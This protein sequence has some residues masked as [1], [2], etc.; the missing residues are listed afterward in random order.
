[1][2]YKITALKVQKRNPNRVNLYLDGEYAFGLSRIVAAWLSIGQALN[3]ERIKELQEQ[4]AD[5]V[6]LQSAL[7]YLNYRPRTEAE[8]SKHLV[9]KGFSEAAVDRVMNRLREGRLLDDRQFARDWVENQNTFRPRGK[10]AL[11]FELR[12]KGISDEIIEQALADSEDEAELAYQAAYRQAQRLCGS[13]WQE[14]RLKLSQYLARRG[15]NYEIASAAV[16]RSWAELCS[17]QAQDS[18]EDMNGE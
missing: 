6:A 1:M 16:R 3:D 2:D 8:I 4:D 12:H 14:F 9:E 17:S 10:R 18:V 15:F 5:E 11:A 7:R 13:E